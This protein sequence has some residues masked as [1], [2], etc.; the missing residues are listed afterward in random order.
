[1]RPA[2]GVQADPTASKGEVAEGSLQSIPSMVLACFVLLSRMQEQ[3]LRLP[4]K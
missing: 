1:M 2:H 3:P 4:L